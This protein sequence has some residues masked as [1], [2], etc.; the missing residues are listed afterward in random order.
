M[1]KTLVTVQAQ[2]VDNIGNIDFNGFATQDNI[3]QVLVQ[4]RILQDDRSNGVGNSFTAFGEIIKGDGVNGKIYDIY[5]GSFAEAGTRPRTDT[6]A[7]TGETLVFNGVSEANVSEIFN[8]LNAGGSNVKH[9]R[10]TY[11][12]IGFTVWKTVYTGN[13]FV[14]P[15]AYPGTEYDRR[16]NT[17]AVSSF[18]VDIY[19]GKYVK[20]SRLEG[21]QNYDNLDTEQLQALY[22]DIGIFPID[23]LSGE[24][25]LAT[26]I[27]SPY[28]ISVPINSV[29][30]ERQDSNNSAL[31]YFYVSDSESSVEAYYAP[32]INLDTRKITGL[33]IGT[34]DG[35]LH[36][37]KLTD[38]NWTIETDDFEYTSTANPDINTNID[39]GTDTSAS[40]TG[41][42]KISELDKITS[43]DPADLMIISRDEDNN[44]TYDKSFAIDPTLLRDSAR[45]NI[46]T[47]KPSDPKNGEFWF[48][49]NTANL[50]IYT[51]ALNS[52]IQI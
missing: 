8:Y 3:N 15:S 22:S 10:F 23:E 4:H 43:F 39:T 48:D 11:S 49:E 32:M 18:A 5:P 38:H 36:G 44:G 26:M 20:I 30:S 17:N 46:G 42:I 13:E 40:Q 21:A 9:T 31:S 12:T 6:N 41:G 33:P 14:F 28:T 19:W 50:Y 25:N 1:A 2:N 24:I 16:M 51:E 52:W 47:E 37:H 35:S 29:Y 34:R 7:I 27:G 45:S